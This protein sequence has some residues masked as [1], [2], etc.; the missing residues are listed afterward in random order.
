MIEFSLLVG[1]LLLIVVGILYFGRYMNY[2]VDETHMANAAARLAAVNFQP[3]NGQSLQSYVQQ[4]ADSNELKN[5]G[6]QVYIYA[7]GASTAQ[8]GQPITA[9]VQANFPLLPFL[10]TH[11]SVTVTRWATMMAEQ[12]NTSWTPSQDPPANTSCPP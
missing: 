4:T 7:N 5:D 8:Y 11:P 9:C 10:G 12:P 6:V 3:P 1:V 2:D